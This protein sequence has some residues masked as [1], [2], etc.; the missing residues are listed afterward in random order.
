LYSPTSEKYLLEIVGFWTPEYLTK[1]IDKIN[2]ANRNDLL[3]VVNE[4]LN[5][6]RDDF[7]GKVVYYKSRIK[8]EEV[9]GALDGT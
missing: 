6:S 8:V 4:N 3:I 9:L 1:K 2:R 7:K 5:C